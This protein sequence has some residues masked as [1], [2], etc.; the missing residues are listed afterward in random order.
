MEVDSKFPLSKQLLTVLVVH[1]FAQLTTEFLAEIPANGTVRRVSTFCWVLRRMVQKGNYRVAGFSHALSNAGWQK[2][3]TNAQLTHTGALV[4]RHI[5]TGQFH[6][7]CS[8][9]VSSAATTW[10]HTRD[11]NVPDSVPQAAL[12]NLRRDHTQK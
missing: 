6:L 2:P 12:P 7:S 8:V 1:N 11:D 9:P 4:S 10:P 3:L 5:L